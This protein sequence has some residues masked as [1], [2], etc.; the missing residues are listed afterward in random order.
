MEPSPVTEELVADIKLGAFE[1]PASRFGAQ[2]ESGG[3]A[4]R[5]SNAHPD[6]P[7]VPAAR[8]SGATAKI[9]LV[10]RPFQM[11][12]IGSDHAHLVQGFSLHLAACLVRFREWTVIDRPPAA[13]ALPP[14]DQRAQSASRPPPIRREMKS[15]W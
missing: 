10:L 7:I 9:R 14:P 8:H 11:H 1:R 3:G 13:V 6:R 4:V 15:T 5:T 2:S 12:G